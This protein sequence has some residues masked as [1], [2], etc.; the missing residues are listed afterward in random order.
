[1]KRLKAN[2]ISVNIGTPMKLVGLGKAVTSSLEKNPVEDEIYLT[3]LNLEGDKQADLDN[4]GGEDKALCV[5]P[6]DYYPYWEEKAGQRLRL[7][8]F[9]ENLT[10]KGLVEEAVC[11]GDVFQWGEAQVQ[12]SQPRIP[13][14]KVA[15]RFGMKELPNE[16]IKTGYT[17]FYMRVI[18]EG[19]VSADT[20]LQ[21]VKRYSDV[22]VSLVNEIY[23]SDS[24]NK[25]AINQIINVKELAYVWRDQM[26]KK[27]EEM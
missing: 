16:I 9:G 27:L 19:N 4:H 2:I 1:M 13:C 8:A 21:F 14:Y 17:G 12:V 6:F 11:I 25:E 10:V 20:P 24:Y 18:K 3:K 5:Y 15:M 22:S 7:G 23:Y 26:K